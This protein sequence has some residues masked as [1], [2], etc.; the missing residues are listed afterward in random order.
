MKDLNIS[1]SITEYSVNDL[2]YVNT[3]E[4]GNII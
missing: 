2:R 3:N 4:T 1:A